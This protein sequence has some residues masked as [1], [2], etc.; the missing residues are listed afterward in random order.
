MHVSANNVTITNSVLQG[1]GAPD[2]FALETEAGANITGLTISNNLIDGWNDGVALQQGT[3]AVI[4]GNTF[5]DMVNLALRLDGVTVATNVSANNFLNNSGPGGH[6]GVTVFEGDFDVGAVVG[7]NT[8][9]ASGGRIGIFANDDAPQTI[10]GTQFGDFMFD[11]SVGG[12]AQTFHGGAGDNSLNGGAGNDT[13]D[14]GTGID[15]LTGG[16]GDDIYM[17]DNV[18]DTVTEAPLQGT[19]TVQSSITYNL[20]DTAANVENLTLTGTGNIN[21]T[22]NGLAN[23]ITGNN[24]D[25]VLDGSVGADTMSGGAGSDSTCRHGRGHRHRKASGE[26]ASTRVQARLLTTRSPAV[27]NLVFI[28]AARSPAPAIARQRHL[29]GNAGN[30][31]LDGERRQR[32][33]CGASPANDTYLIDDA[34]DTVVE[35]SP[36]R[37][38]TRPV[39]RELHARLQCR[40]AD[41]YRGGN[42]QRRRQQPSPTSSTATAAATSHRSRRQRHAGRRGR[43]RH[44]SAAWATTPTSSTMPATW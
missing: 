36:T 29:A 34:L 28:G 27:D 11:A 19:D 31:I 24:G 44:L 18:G 43:R 7:V 9:D 20:N 14:G 32:R 35:S 17:V 37:E 42:D 33:P 22:G 30:D 41:P 16:I 15:T 1:A 21:G 6:I 26:A 39:V 23:T 3:A 40:E 13:L 12:Q 8:M 38:P 5:Q 2:T 4:T 25:N 10:T